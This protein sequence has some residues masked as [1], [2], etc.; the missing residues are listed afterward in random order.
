VY[1]AFCP[2]DGEG[3]P[4]HTT[5]IRLAQAL[6]T[7]VLKG[8]LECLVGLARQ[9]KVVRGLKLR[10]DT[11]VV[12]TNIHHPTDGRLLQDGVQVITSTVKKIMEKVGEG[13]R[14]FR[15]RSRSVG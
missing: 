11:T 9:R 8:I 2:I 12:E 15:E 14:R 6:G 7:E 1:R 10:V 13:K 5:L 3:L 4:H